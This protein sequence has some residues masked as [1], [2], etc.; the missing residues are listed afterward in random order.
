MCQYLVLGFPSVPGIIGL[1]EDVDADRADVGAD[2][3]DHH[4]A[5]PAASGLFHARHS[6]VVDQGA[7]ALGCRCEPDQADEDC[8]DNHNAGYQERDLVSLRFDEDQRQVQDCE[9]NEGGKVARRHS[10]TRQG[11]VH[12]SELRPDRRDEHACTLA[13]PK[14][15]RGE[16]DA[17]KEYPLNDDEDEASGSP[18]GLLYD[19]KAN[20]PFRT[21]SAAGHAE[22]ADDDVA[23]DDCQHSLP[24]VEPQSNQR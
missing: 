22:E 3:K 23:D 1:D 11:S 14:D 13:S 9:D 6:D 8:R 5:Q 20:V 16:P 18:G 7:S 4:P 10:P 12:L 19:G 21:W 15:L 17:S 24:H 2:T